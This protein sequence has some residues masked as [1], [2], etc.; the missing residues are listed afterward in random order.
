MTEVSMEEE[1]RGEPAA[2][3]DSTS[4]EEDDLDNTSIPHKTLAHRSQESKPERTSKRLGTLGEG[5]EVGQSYEHEDEPTKSLDQ[6]GD[7]VD[8]ITIMPWLTSSQSQNRP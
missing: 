5:R 2:F 6:P 7:I 8:L 4:S 1:Q 3:D